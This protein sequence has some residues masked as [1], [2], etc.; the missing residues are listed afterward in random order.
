ML[1]FAED[2]EFIVPPAFEHCG[3]D[4]DDESFQPDVLDA[5]ALEHDVLVEC[6]IIPW[7][8]PMPFSSNY[9]WEVYE[10]NKIAPH[11]WSVSTSVF[12][13]RVR[14]SVSTSVQSATGSRSSMGTEA[15]FLA[16][17]LASKSRP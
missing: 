14:P 15:Q 17:F 2:R 6:K 8:G 7:A 16:Q 1:A 3:Y 11:A 10:S 12:L 13:R 9:Q 5:A 4:V